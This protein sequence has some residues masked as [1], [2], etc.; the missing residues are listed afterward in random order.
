MATGTRL[1]NTQE[2]LLRKLL[3]QIAEMKLSDDADPDFIAGLEGM[4][5]AKIREPIERA[6]AAALTAADP[7]LAGVGGAG[8][9]G[10]LSGAMGGMGG[11]GGM[12]GGA[13]GADPTLLLQALAAGGTQPQTIPNQRGL[14][15]S[16][17]I[18]GSV[19]ELRRIM[20]R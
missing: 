14:V 15:A 4:L 17:D 11:M 19:D 8:G 12:T 2:E 13:G 10:D 5:V 20:S 7:A 6:R 1:S 9:M 18:T 3:P 16:P